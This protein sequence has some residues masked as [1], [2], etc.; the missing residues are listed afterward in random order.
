[1]IEMLTSRQILKQSLLML[2]ECR[3][4]NAPV[5]WQEPDELRDQAHEQAS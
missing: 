1:M 5:D 3:P 4:L 2:G